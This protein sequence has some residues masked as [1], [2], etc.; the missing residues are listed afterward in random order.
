MK[1]LSIEKMNVPANMLLTDWM[2]LNFKRAFPDADHGAVPLHV[3]HATRPEFGDYQCNAAM[4][5]AKVLKMPPR[6]VAAQII[7]K[8]VPQDWVAKMEVAGAGFINIFLSDEWLARRAEEIGRD[9]ERGVPKSGHGRVVIIDYS[10]PNVAKP[11]HIGHIR[12]TVIGNAL[13]RIHRFLGYRV[14]SD[15]HLGDWG[16]QFGIIIMGY[17]NFLNQN[18]LQNS[19][20][21]ELERVYVKSYEK[22]AQD[23]DWM[24]QCRRELV[25]LQAG[26]RENTALWEQF[27]KFSMEEFDK[28]YRRLDVKFD[29]VRG[30]SF[31]HKKLPPLISALAEKN[32]IRESEGAL[33]A[34]LDENKLPPAIVRKSDGAFNYLATDIATVLS[35]NEEFQPEKII[36]VTDE[37]QQLH[38]KQL[39]AVCRRMGIKT[40]LEHVWFGLMRLPQGTFST[41]EGNVIKL[42]KLLDEAEARAFELV[43][44][45]NPEMPAEEQ[46]EV[47]RAVGIGAVKYADLCQNPQSVVTFNWDKAMALN[48]NSAPYLQYTYARIRSVENKYFAAFPQKDFHSF[49]ILL[50]E[51]QE[52]NL[53]LILARF[54]EIVPL[55]AQLYKP[56]VLADYLYQL[57]SE[58][59]LFYQNVPFLKAADGIRESRVRLGSIIAGVLKQGLQLLGIDTP[60]R[61]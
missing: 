56:N 41:R 37:R 23:K 51:P 30:E 13:D 25:K 42:E 5:L 50:K 55:A 45:I 11:M 58:Y 35:R 59:N 48:G 27:V 15:N 32:I 61:I 20:V 38:F 22:T 36:Y 1:T 33:V 21:E 47:A 39:F 57:A 19:P 8:A 16:T 6:A 40:G 10:S 4:T 43:R 18:A 24:E 53:A 28:I 44:E 26:D 3:T 29:F 9:P 52:R 17:R 54:A 2:R 46:K 7:E 60:E 14:I 34:F 31:Y 12:S 49:D